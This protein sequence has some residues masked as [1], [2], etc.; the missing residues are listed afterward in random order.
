MRGLLRFSIG[1]LLIM[2]LVYLGAGL[3]WVVRL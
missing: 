3:L 1:A 2:V